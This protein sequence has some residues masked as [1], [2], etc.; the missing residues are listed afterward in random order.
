MT[1]ASRNLRQ[2]SEI[3]SLLRVDE[4]LDKLKAR[5]PDKARPVK[6]RFCSGLTNEEAVASR[7]ISPA[8]AKRY[9]T[10]ARTILTA[11]ARVRGKSRLDRWAVKP[12]WIGN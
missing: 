12:R 4:A 3:G 10:L 1:L 8:T 6:L 9:W 11:L 2:K 5:D 7:D